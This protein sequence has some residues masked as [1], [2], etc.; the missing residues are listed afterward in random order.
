M[1]LKW[2][3]A[4]HMTEWEYQVDNEEGRAHRGHCT[5]ASEGQ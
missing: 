2:G 1:G 5:Q 3:P 4:K